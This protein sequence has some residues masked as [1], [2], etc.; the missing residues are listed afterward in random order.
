MGGFTIEFRIVVNCEETGKGI[1]REITLETNGEITL[2]F[3]DRIVDTVA[4]HRSGLLPWGS[5][6]PVL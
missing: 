6:S 5:W 2:M 1:K 4:H 3:A